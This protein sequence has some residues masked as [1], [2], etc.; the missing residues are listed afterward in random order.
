MILKL[1]QQPN[2]KRKL[3]YA[4]YD[5]LFELQRSN[6]DGMTSSQRNNIRSPISESRDC[7]DLSNSQSVQRII[8]RSRALKGITALMLVML[9]ITTL[10]YVTF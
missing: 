8:V 4:V 10:H 3:V 2:K 6:L 5:D 9:F 1:F 7:Y